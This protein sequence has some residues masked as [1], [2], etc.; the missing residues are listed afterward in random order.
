MRNRE[1]LV[2][3]GLSVYDS[4]LS[5]ARAGFDSRSGKHGRKSFFGWCFLLRSACQPEILAACSKPPACELQRQRNLFGVL[6]Q[7]LDFAPL[8]VLC[9]ARRNSLYLLAEYCIWTCRSN[10]RSLLRLSSV[11]L[12]EG[13]CGP[14]ITETAAPP[15]V[16][17]RNSPL[18]SRSIT[19]TMSRSKKK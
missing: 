15:R 11:I 19:Q 5:H 9:R 8:G 16:A 2:P 18:R 14:P 13:N 17:P 1:S 7:G 3:D 6:T 4:R 12:P 10:I